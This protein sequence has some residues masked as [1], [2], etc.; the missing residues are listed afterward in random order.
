MRLTEAQV[1]ETF[2]AVVEEFGPTYR[3]T[4]DGIEYP[5]AE[6]GVTCAYE[7]IDADDTVRRCVVGEILHRLVDED[8]WS[9]IVD[10]NNEDSVVTIVHERDISAPRHVLDGLSQAQQAQDRG[11]TWGAALAEYRLFVDRR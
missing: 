8:T 5:S 3:Y 9:A 11:A 4:P 2:T 7:T 6:S 10:Y 1:T